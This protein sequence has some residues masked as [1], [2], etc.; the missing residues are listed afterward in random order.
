MHVILDSNVYISDYRMESISFKNLFDY[1]RRTG[2]A[3]VLF[4]IVREEVVAHFTIDLKR[5]ANEAEKAWKAYRHLHF[6]NKLAKFTEP[7]IA[8][9]KKLLRDRLMK[10]SDAFRVVYE[11]D[12]SRISVDD[13]FVR[14]I[15]RIPPASAD[16]EELRDVILWLSA[17]DYGKSTKHELAFI[18]AD[19]GFWSNN[20][21]V[22]PEIQ[23]DIKRAEVAIRLYRNIDRFVE[24][25][26]P[27]VKAADE[28]LAMKLFPEFSGA[29]IAAA[30]SAIRS[31]RAFLGLASSLTLESVQFK[32]GTLFDVAPDVQ[33]AELL[34]TVHIQFH[35][36]TV[37]NPVFMPNLAAEINPNLFSG[38]SFSNLPLQNRPYES[39]VSGLG[40]LAGAANWIGTSW[41]SSQIHPTTVDAQYLMIG[42]V[43]AFARLLKGELSEKE[44]TEFTI[45]KI[46]RAERPTGDNSQV[47]K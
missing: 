25:N 45:E 15:H 31:G 34:F 33:V 26:S 5:R 39:L 46:D 35:S 1:L 44:V 47:S 27:D 23:E 13:V 43:R 8:V 11:N 41:G 18:T 2:D 24:E 22:L 19:S 42:T 9:Q 10:P 30:E 21:E 12:T 29:V 20:D 6:P 32:E 16:G 37:T 7:N 14:G 4:R 17:L 36:Q 28:D 38:L 3:L 40:G